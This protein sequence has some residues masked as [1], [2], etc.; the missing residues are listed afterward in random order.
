[1]PVGSN[2]NYLTGKRYGESVV[3]KLDGIADSGLFF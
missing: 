3:S 1:M 2:R